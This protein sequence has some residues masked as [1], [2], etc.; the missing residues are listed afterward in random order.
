[1]HTCEDALERGE[2]STNKLQSLEEM[3]EEYT[4]LFHGNGYVKTLMT[5]V[6]KEVKIIGG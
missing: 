6:R 3:Y 1:M 5:R 2:M 4:D